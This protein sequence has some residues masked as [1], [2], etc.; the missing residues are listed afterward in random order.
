VG[1]S[2]GLGGERRRAVVFPFPAIRERRPRGSGTLPRGAWRA[3]VKT[4]LLSA[5]MILA[6]CLGAAVAQTTE[7]DWQREAVRRYPALGVAGSPLN[8]AFLAEYQRRKQT[9]SQAAFFA[10]P[11]WPMLLADDCARQM[12]PGAA[13]AASPASPSTQW[14]MPGAGTIPNP[15]APPR[16][17]PKPANA[18]S[19]ALTMLLALGVGVLIALLIGVVFVKI[20]TQMVAGFT[21]SF[22]MACT[23]ILLS[24]GASI[25]IT[26][27]VGVLQASNGG[28]P[29]LGLSLISLIVSI[30]VHA[31]IYGTVLRDGTTPIGSGKG[32]LVNLVQGILMILA[33]L[34][35]VVI[36]VVA[37]VSLPAYS[38][39]QQKLK[40]A[41]SFPLRR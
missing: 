35:I 7:A 2:G 29:S 20:A 18:G 16:F 40:D 22:G 9:H 6:I 3:L 26:I 39:M 23:A 32:C 25:L 28:Q 4:K 38:Q 31:A 17:I 41:Q 30:A 21:P 1:N 15:N 33:V 37:G 19:I 12:A 34:C 11:R 27:V 8:K 24:F 14:T 10:N 36:C 5:L 13:P